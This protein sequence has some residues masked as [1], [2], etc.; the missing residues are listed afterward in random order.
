MLAPPFL[1]TKIR[2]KKGVPFGTPS[3]IPSRDFV[4][5]LSLESVNLIFNGGSTHIHI[6]IRHQLP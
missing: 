5:L 1:F 2:K 4:S 3:D 6:N